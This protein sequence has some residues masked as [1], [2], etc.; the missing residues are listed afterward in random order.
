MRQ[1]QKQNKGYKYLLT[2]IDVIS[3]KLLS[4]IRSLLSGRAQR[5]KVGNS[6]S[7]ERPVLS[8]VPQGSVLGPILFLLFVNDL[9]NHLP[10]NAKS[11]LFADDLKSY[12]SVSDK[13]LGTGIPLLLEAITDWSLTWQLPL[14]PAKCNW[15]LISNLRSPSNFSFSLSGCCLK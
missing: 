2:V 13:S 15:M 9:S 11:K 3:G 7:V 1:Y 5:V 12:L 6:L 10:P 4:C 14:S 8:G